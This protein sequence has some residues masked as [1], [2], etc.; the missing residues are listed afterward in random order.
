MHSQKSERSHCPASTTQSSSATGP[1]TASI[2]S[3]R[4]ISEAGRLSSYPPRL[5]QMLLMSL[6]RFNGAVSCERY[7]LGR[8]CRAAT[9]RSLTGSPWPYLATSAIMRM[10]YRTR[11]LMCIGEVDRVDELGQHSPYKK[12]EAARTCLTVECDLNSGAGESRPFLRV[13]RAPTPAA[14][15]VAVD[16]D[17]D[18]FLPDHVRGVRPR[19]SPLSR[20]ARKGPLS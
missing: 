20:D 9:S 15:D 17:L 5:P 1:S 18:S 10:A 11:V 19:H 12:T 2:M 14:F 13:E 4:L 3:S 7:I 6:A 8:F 16:L